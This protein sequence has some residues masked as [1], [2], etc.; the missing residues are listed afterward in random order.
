MV[1]SIDAIY[2]GGVFRPTSDAAPPLP[3][4]AEVRLTVEPVR[5]P[6]VSDVL[7]LGASVYAGLC[8]EEVAEVE[9]IARDRSGFFEPPSRIDGR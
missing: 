5:E 8:E 4:G 6:A 3:D 9:R 7:A 1:H 2:E